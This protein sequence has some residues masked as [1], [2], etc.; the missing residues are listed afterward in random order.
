MTLPTFSCCASVKRPGADL[1][2]DFTS[3]PGEISRIGDNYLVVVP[4]AGGEGNAELILHITRQDIPEYKCGL[5]HVAGI[6]PGRIE[7]HTRV[8]GG[9]P[10]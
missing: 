2:F 5:E 1:R 6:A 7:D 3:E 8:V 4:P 10:C 9:G